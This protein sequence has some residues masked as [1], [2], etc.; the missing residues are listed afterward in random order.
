MPL[1][2][3]E[4]MHAGLPVIASDVGSVVEAVSEG[5]S[6]FVVTPED[7]AALQARLAE[8]LADPQLRR[9]MGERGRSLAA[10]CFTDAVMARR[11]EAIYRKMIERGGDSPMRRPG[12]AQVA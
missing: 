7:V 5:E 12:R 8:L 9:R 1:G 10:E 11:Y 3:I 2:I 4:A 6:G